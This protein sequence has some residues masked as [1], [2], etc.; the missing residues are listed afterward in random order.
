MLFSEINPFVRYARRLTVHGDANYQAVVPLDTRL[1]FAVEGSGQI[2]VDGVTY[3]MH[4]NALLIVASG[5][6]YQILT[7][8][9]WVQYVAVNFDYT[10]TA[11]HLSLPIAPLPTTA[12]HR[13]N[14]ID[15]VRIDDQTALCHVFYLAKTDGIQKKLTT[16]VQ[17]YTQK[18][19]YHTQKCGHL[20]A[21]SI[22]DALRSSE[23]G[24]A[25]K[26]QE[27]ASRILAYVQTHYAEE[28]TNGSIGTAFGYHPNYLN[29]LFINHSGQT[30][31]AYLQSVRIMQAIH[32]LQTTDKPVSNVAEEVGFCDIAH[33]SKTFKQKTGHSPSSFR[34]KG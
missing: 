10:Q 4:P 23:I 1:F 19:R 17:E 6:S 21:E 20:L 2:L 26:E 8:S 5:V 33:F 34:I 22:T 28:V 7:P 31:Y 32:L 30:L 18:L 29:H 12:F 13:Q 15:P 16:L 25:T 3:D 14:L 11:S 24:F 9:K 27:L